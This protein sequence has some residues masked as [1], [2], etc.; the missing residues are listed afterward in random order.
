MMKKT[1]SS[2]SFFTTLL[3]LRM[4]PGGGRGRLQGQRPS[5]TVYLSL[6]V[7][8][9][10]LTCKKKKKKLKKQ[11]RA[12]LKFKSLI[13]NSVAWPIQVPTSVRAIQLY[14]KVYRW[15][16]SGR[17]TRAVYCMSS[18]P[19]GTTSDN[20]ILGLNTISL[21]PTIGTNTG[22]TFMYVPMCVRVYVYVCICRLDR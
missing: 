17:H 21:R 12:K 7:S 11:P 16:V 22:H 6:P 2:Y 9:W 13:R 1:Y 4:V 5:L 19:T 20:D 8:P 3:D 18:K 14:K 10:R 15:S